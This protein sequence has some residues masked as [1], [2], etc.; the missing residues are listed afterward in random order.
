MSADLFEQYLG[1]D[2]YTVVDAADDRQGPRRASGGGYLAPVTTNPVFPPLAPTFRD[3]LNTAA[4]ATV[5][6]KVV[7]AGY[8]LMSE[9]NDAFDARAAA[10]L[11]DSAYESKPN[12]S[13]EL[14]K[15]AKA[16]WLMKAR[17]ADGRRNAFKLTHRGAERVRE[18][19]NLQEGV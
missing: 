1:D 14:E 7:L 19:V 8:F 12:F 9:G 15:A 5:A 13:R 11:F 18:V 2:D 10:E 16:G 4:R 6:D 3:M 17:T